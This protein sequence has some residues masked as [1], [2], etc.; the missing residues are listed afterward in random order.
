MKNDVKIAY[1]FIAPVV[2]VIVGVVAYPFTK[3]II[4]SMTK[5]FIGSGLQGFLGFGNYISLLSH[6]NTFENTIIA[7]NMFRQIFRI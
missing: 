4:T 1:L 3:A 2:I 6:N 7:T 5:H